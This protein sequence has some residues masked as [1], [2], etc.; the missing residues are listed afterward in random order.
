MRDPELTMMGTML[1]KLSEYDRSRCENV[2]LGDS[3]AFW[4]QTDTLERITGQ[5]Y[6]NFGIPGAN[7]DV[8]IHLFWHINQNVR[9]RNVY[10]TINFHDYGDTWRRDLLEEAKAKKES[11]YPFFTTPLLVKQAFH[12]T[13]L[14]LKNKKITRCRSSKTGTQIPPGKESFAP[15]GP[16]FQEGWDWSVKIVTASL[17]RYVYPDDYYRRL[18]EV[19]KYC[20][21]NNIN[22]VFIIVPNQM[23][24]HDLVRQAD[25]ESETERFKND[26]RSLGETYDF[27]YKNDIT[28]TKAY[29]SDLLHF[30]SYVYSVIYNEVWRHEKG[31]AIHT[32]PD[33]IR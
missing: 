16:T 12:I 22:L 26:I 1:W 21:K 17:K 23:E 25:L 20:E 29:Y 27:D 7:P 4:I 24:F 33:P 19:S 32:Y 5:S 14:G 3:R 13:S 9:L 31:V 11:I 30:S 18:K 28:S 8:L 15:R 10:L 2:I 6:Y